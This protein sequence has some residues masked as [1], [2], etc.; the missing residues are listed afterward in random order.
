M[1]ATVIGDALF[2]VQNTGGEDSFQ[3]RSIEAKMDKKIATDKNGE[4]CGWTYYG[5][6]AEHTLELL[7]EIALASY[8]VGV[9]GSAPV[10]C[11]AFVAGTVWCVDEVSCGRTND[12]YSKG[13]VKISEYVI[14]D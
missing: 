14:E 12:N 8:A 11:S 6:M 5:K 4:D 2:G 13:N 7:S 3:S 9:A 10:H 1:A